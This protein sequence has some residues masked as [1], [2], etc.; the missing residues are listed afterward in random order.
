MPGDSP[1]G[2]I[3][4]TVAA[5]LALASAGHTL[6]L[7]AFRSH[8]R[9]LVGFLQSAES[10]QD[11]ERVAIDLAIRAA[12]RGTAPPGDWLALACK[13]GLGWKQLERAL[14]H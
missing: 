13:A 14:P 10:A 7:D 1:A 2:R 12:T 5:V 9:R 4:R 6:T 3:A 8:V 11:R